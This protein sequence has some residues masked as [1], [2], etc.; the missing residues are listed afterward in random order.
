[1][2]AKR[3][4][5]LI[6]PLLLLAMKA[7]VSAAPM[8]LSQL[9]ASADGDGNCVVSSNTSIVSASGPLT[10]ARNL[11][12]NPGVVL[13]YRVPVRIV[14]GGNLIVSGTLG[15]PGDGGDGGV[16]GAAGQPGGPG[17]AAP[18][19]V[20]GTL[21]VRGSIFLYGTGAMVAEG[22]AGGAG[23][24][25]GT[26]QPGGAGGAGGA[27]GTLTLNTCAAFTGLAG[28]QIRVGGGA[29]GLGQNAAL[30]GVGG[31]GGAVIVN[32]GQ[33][34]VSSALISALGGAGGNG[35]AGAGGAGAHGAITL[36]AGGPITLDSASLSAGSNNTQTPNQV[37][38]AALAYCVGSAHTITA[39]AI[40]AQAGTVICTPSV[41]LDG[42]SSTC[43]A[44]ANTG[45]KFMGFSGDCAGPSCNLTNVTSPKSV[46]AEFIS[47]DVA[48]IPTLSEWAMLLMSSLIA[49]FAVWRL[50]RS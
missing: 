15:A 11:T 2:R 9:C 13:E 49:A 32:A 40:P 41:V 22:G 31:A 29:G 6:V 10:V 18:A 50:R 17:G 42:G 44:S 24:L 1:M 5:L 23:G 14:V 27:G 33:N 8:D 20:N 36:N 19:V 46:T 12:I 48:A 25:G 45:Y 7:P 34:I 30:G 4:S 16:G 37:S 26:G 21:D 3:W 43:T 47:A 38:N 39:V 35:G 28:G